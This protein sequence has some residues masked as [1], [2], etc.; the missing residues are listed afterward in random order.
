MKKKPDAETTGVLYEVVLLRR[1][2]DRDH[3]KGQ[4]P[5][6]EQQ[7]QQDGDSTQTVHHLNVPGGAA[8]GAPGGD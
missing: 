4:L 5:V 7:Y 1:P 2:R 8:G 6:V 3:P